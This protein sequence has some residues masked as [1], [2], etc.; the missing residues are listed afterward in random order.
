[1]ARLFNGA[2]GGILNK[3]LVKELK[4]DIVSV[5]F[6]ERYLPLVPFEP[7]GLD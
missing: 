6:S 2:D 4:P 1:L 3:D 5:Q 7:L